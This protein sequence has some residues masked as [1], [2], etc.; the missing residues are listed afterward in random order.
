MVRVRVRVRV[1]ITITCR[2]RSFAHFPVIALPSRVAAY[3]PSTLRLPEPPMLTVLWKS[4]A[5]FGIV[6]PV[7]TA[8]CCSAFRGRVDIAINAAVCL[9]LLPMC[10]EAGYMK[11]SVNIH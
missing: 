1:R 11:A 5:R 2:I 6:R 3:S 4:A 10:D 8:A 9:L 7:S